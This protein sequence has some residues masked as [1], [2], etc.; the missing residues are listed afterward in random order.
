M[1][2]SWI[3]LSPSLLANETSPLNP[4]ISSNDIDRIHLAVGQLERVQLTSGLFPYDFD[5]ATGQKTSMENIG[6]IN[7]VRQTGAALALGEYLT[8]YNR[9]STQK[10]LKKFLINSA[11]N[12]LPIGKS[13]TQQTLE[14]F[15]IYNRWRFWKTLREPLYGMGLLFSKEGNAKV[16][17]TENDYE[18]AW[19]GANALNLVAAIKYYQATGDTTF[20]DDIVLWKN[21]LLA[22]KVPERGF[23]EAP[24]YL[25]E[26]PYFNGESWLAL[27]EY[28]QAFPNDESLNE[29]IVEID[30]YMIDRYSRQYNAR[31]YSWGTMAANVRAQTTNDKRFTDLIYALTQQYLDKNEPK[32]IPSTNS[33]G[34]VEGMATF[35]ATMQTQNRADD[36]L[37]R[38][39]TVY[40]EKLMNVNR[41]LQ[42]SKNTVATLPNGKRFA[43]KIEEYEGA[44]LLSLK[45]PL[46]QV[47]IT[48][49][50]LNALLRME[51]AGL[52][53]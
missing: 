11:S 23:R 45:Q 41:N 27:A 39:A 31:F 33:C 8:H 53:H 26:S 49:H 46:M 38:R 6:G 3:F 20:N 10:V 50:C 25:T 4:S 34:V 37:V 15:G 18:R 19:T 7:L 48:Q 42:L 17:S 51:A 13:K 43:N 29:V 16:V 22:L 47:D 40:I 44:F 9:E 36:P 52:T 1:F 21:G 14:S 35:V 12:S 32:E 28:I 2:S 5:F 30:S 24:H